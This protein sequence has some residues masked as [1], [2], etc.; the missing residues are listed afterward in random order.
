VIAIGLM[1]G[2]SLDG[3]DAALVEIVPRDQGYALDLLHFGTYAFDDGLARALH[4]ALPPNDGSVAVVAALHHALGEAFADAAQRAAGTQS[5][6]Y[7]ASHGQT[8]WHDGARRVTLQLGDPFAIRE[9]VG[10]TVCFD[11]RS[12]DCAAGGH[13]AP[14]VAHVDALLFATPQ[15]DRVAVNLGG[16]ANV[17]LLR[18]NGDVIA[19]DTGPGNMLVDAFVRA[20]SGGQQTFDRDG[21][22]AAQGAVDEE[23]LAAM[24]DDDYFTQAPPK[25]TGRERFGAQFLARHGERLSRLSLED[26]LATLSELTAASV[27][28]AVRDAVAMPARAIV[29][30]GGARNR[31]LMSR[32]ASRLAPARV[33]TSDAM[34][35]PPDAKEAMAFAVLGYETL[36]GRAANVP[37]ATGAQR[38]VPLGAIAP[39]RLDELL[40]NVERE[41]RT[42]S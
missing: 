40:A 17:T 41:C 24:L 8:V 29:S 19:F 18:K 16:I 4:A 25:T 6:A 13:G 30:G 20:R 14:L 1:S 36:R 11:F 33:E 32:L 22:L 28:D 12:A 7:V 2:T 9:R 23:L 35:I 34:G 37:R 10:A 15:E 39:Y 27:A 3:I 26:G 38:A 21:I 5:V 31:H 42:S